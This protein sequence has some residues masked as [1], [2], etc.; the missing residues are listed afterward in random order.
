MLIVTTDGLP[1]FE[2]RT[3]LG[4]VFGVAVQ[5]D[6]GHAPSPG[7]PSSATFSRTGEQAVGLAQ[8]RR[9]AVKRLGDEARRLGAN[10]VLGMSF[11]N[12]F[13]VGG[14]HE[15][16]AYGTAVWAE[17]IQGQQQHHAQQPQSQNSQQLPP[18]GG[19]PQPGR[20]P[21]VGRNLTI[22]LHGDNPR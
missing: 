17:Q 15:V 9:E 3:V 20:T 4:E 19:E 14:A 21:V 8:A 10:A 22:G 1:G 5:T 12:A 2:I 18:Y 13:M 11:D 16:C 6:Q 7:S